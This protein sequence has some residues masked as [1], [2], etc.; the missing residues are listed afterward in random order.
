MIPSLELSHF[1][2]GGTCENI[3]RSLSL[4]CAQGFGLGTSRNHKK[5]YRE[6]LLCFPKLL[7]R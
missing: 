4:W 1:L 5:S 6:D 2:T 3:L 7:L